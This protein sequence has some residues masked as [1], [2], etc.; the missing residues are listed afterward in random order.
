MAQEK[1][2]SIHPEIG[3][4][5]SLKEKKDFF[6]FPHIQDDFFSYALVRQLNN[7]FFIHYYTDSVSSIEEID[8][9][10]L[11][12][13]FEDIEKQI[14]SSGKTGKLNLRQLETNN[15]NPEGDRLITP[16]DKKNIGYKKEK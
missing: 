2:I 5:I 6:L 9:T 4:T 1:I 16:E 7:S 10:D 3:D 8:S 15:K 11:S 14:K 13:Y 12:R